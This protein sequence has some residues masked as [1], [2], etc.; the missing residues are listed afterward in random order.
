MPC[1][2]DI[3]CIQLA[4]CMHNT[5]EPAPDAKLCQCREEFT[6]EDGACNGQS[7]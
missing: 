2:L 3:Q 7:D 5:S 4:Y 1:E 6:D